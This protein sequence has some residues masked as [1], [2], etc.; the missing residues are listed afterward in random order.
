MK[1]RKFIEKQISS[2]KL[3]LSSHEKLNEFQKYNREFLPIIASDDAFTKLKNVKFSDDQ[4][5]ALFMNFRDSY[6]SELHKH[7]NFNC[8]KPAK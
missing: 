2:I 3:A 5:E 1:E 7:T 6:I 4:C 8:E